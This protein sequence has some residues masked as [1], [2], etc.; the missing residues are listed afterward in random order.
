MTAVYAKKGWKFSD[1]I[2]DGSA[3]P[4]GAGQA[5]GRA[6]APGLGRGAQKPAGSLPQR[7]RPAGLMRFSLPPSVGFGL[8]SHCFEAKR[9]R[10]PPQQRELG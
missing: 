5:V 2:L 6:L 8:S 1:I 9:C 4:L 10:I 7:P 3:A